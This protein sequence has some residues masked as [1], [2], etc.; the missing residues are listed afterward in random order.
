MKTD[1]AHII[2]GIRSGDETAYRLLFE[3]WYQ[4]LV[5]FSNKYLDD[6]EA[7]KDLVQEFFV[8]LYESGDTTNIHSS[9]KSYLFGAVRNRCLNYIKHVEVRARHKENILQAEV[10]NENILEEMMDAV[11]LEEKIYRIVSALPEQCRTNLL[12]EPWGWKIKPGNC[13]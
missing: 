10:N 6:L 8:H 11:E 13:G 12:D 1:D 3:L 4:R 7:S 9:L 5:V 2:K